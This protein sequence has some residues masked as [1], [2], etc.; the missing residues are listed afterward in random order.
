MGRLRPAR[1]ASHSHGNGPLIFPRGVSFKVLGGAR[2]AQIAEA[3][4]KKVE[5]CADYQL[6]DLRERMIRAENAMGKEEGLRVAERES[7][8]ARISALET[9]MGYLRGLLAC[10]VGGSVSFGVCWGV[11]E[12]AKQAADLLP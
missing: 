9:Q 4:D 11:L 6:E 5:G 8:A 1:H 10:V 12:V 7:A 2:K 3:R